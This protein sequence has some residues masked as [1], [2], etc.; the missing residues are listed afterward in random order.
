M[1]APLAAAA[2]RARRYPATTSAGSGATA[3]SIAPALVHGPSKARRMYSSS[4]PVPGSNTATAPSGM[5][6]KV[7]RVSPA[8]HDRAWPQGWAGH[9]GGTVWRCGTS[10]VYGDVCINERSGDAMA[11]AESFM[12][13]LTR[14]L[15]ESPRTAMPRNSPT[16]PP[17]PGAARD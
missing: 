13:R 11:T 6:R 12:R 10:R 17:A 7:F 8:T 16:R 14:R 3:T 4:E 5:L 2:S 15:T 9:W 1:T